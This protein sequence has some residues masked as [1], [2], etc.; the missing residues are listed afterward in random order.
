M[1][2]SDR[3]FSLFLLTLAAVVTVA[4]GW[5]LLSLFLAAGRYIESVP[6]P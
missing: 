2:P 5:L 3:L 4:A 6:L 1:D